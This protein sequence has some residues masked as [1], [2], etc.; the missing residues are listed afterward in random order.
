MSGR[1]VIWGGGNLR[2]M[3][4]SKDFGSFTDNKFKTTGRRMTEH[5]TGKAKK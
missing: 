5:V 2:V 3:T 1:K 4:F